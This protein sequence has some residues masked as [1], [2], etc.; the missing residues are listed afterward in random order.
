MAYF[1]LVFW[2]FSFVPL[3][4]PQE[5]FLGS[6]RRSER[7]QGKLEQRAC[8][9]AEVGMADQREA[10]EWRRERSPRR[11]HDEHLDRHPLET[12]VLSRYFVKWRSVLVGLLVI[13]FSLISSYLL[14][15]DNVRY[16]L[17]AVMVLGLGI[18]I[19]IKPQIGFWAY[20]IMALARP[21]EV[22][23]GFEK[24]RI[25]LGLAVFT[26]IATLVRTS[27]SRRGSPPKDRILLVMLSF[28]VVVAL[29]ALT[30]GGNYERLID[31]TKMLLFAGTFAAFMN[32]R[33]WYKVSIWL[34]TCSFAYLTFWALM[35][36]YVHGVYMLDGPGS[37]S[38]TLKDRNFFAMHLLLAI[39][40]YW[41]L[42][43]RIES[44]FWKLP[45]L[46]MIP[47]AVLCV[48][49]TASRGGL[50]GIAAAFGMIAWQSRHRVPALIGGILLLGG[51]YVVAAPQTLKGRADTI[52]H[53]EGEASA[54]GRLHSWRAGTKMMLSNPFLGVGPAQY[55]SQ[56][57]FYDSSKPRQAHNILVQTGGEYGITG[58]IFLI[59]FHVFVFRRLLRLRDEEGA[60][61]PLVRSWAKTLLA[62]QVAFWVT[63]FFI[64]AERY[65]FGWFIGALAVSLTLT[66]QRE[67]RDF[68]QDELMDELEI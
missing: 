56:Y 54:E 60:D 6:G 32:Q 20:Y 22:L 10:D 30:H 37:A 27:M 17:G 5:L 7:Y 66:L 49:L 25:S 9:S 31:I 2:D 47:L 21:N 4:L 43:E 12:E 36:K 42:A 23:W 67:S 35:Q 13:A 26:L 29:S 28:N 62:S 48:F 40:F 57:R 68:E 63:A 34:V 65:E 55:V 58:L 3:P 38:A 52:V 44:K 33:S 8:D 14:L 11:N 61:D 59:L 46:G 50:L 19:F 16:A 15:H 24:L 53:Y 18:V 1:P 51:F 39:P 64:S 45:A 41:Y